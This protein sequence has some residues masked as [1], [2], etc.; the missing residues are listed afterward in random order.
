MKIIQSKQDRELFVVV[1]SLVS[2]VIGLGLGYGWISA[3]HFPF[4]PRQ[5]QM[6]IFYALFI[7]GG[8]ALAP[9]ATAMGLWVIPHKQ[10]GALAIVMLVIWNQ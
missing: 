5:R 2:Y 1:V 9:F 10:S 7:T 3:M 4:T 6:W 8:C